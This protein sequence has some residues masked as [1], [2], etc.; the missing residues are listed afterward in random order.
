MADEEIEGIKM[1]LIAL[2]TLLLIWPDS[3]QAAETNQQAVSK[4]TVLEWVKQ[5]REAKPAFQPGETLKSADLEKT[6][7]F[8]TSRP[9]RGVRFSRGYV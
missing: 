2:V 1:I 4:E 3:S 9:F 6:P 7:A 5:Y 8:F